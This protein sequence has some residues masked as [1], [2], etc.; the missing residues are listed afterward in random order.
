MNTVTAMVVMIFRF[1][2]ASAV[3]LPQVPLDYSAFKTIA[4]RFQRYWNSD[5]STLNVRGAD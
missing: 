3:M 4:G 1:F 5:L 2:G